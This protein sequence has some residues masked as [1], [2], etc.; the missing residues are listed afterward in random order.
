MLAL[1]EKIDAKEVKKKHF[2]AAMR[3]IGASI[4]EDTIKRYKD[5]ET[6]YLRSAKAALERTPQTYTG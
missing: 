2:D 3:K 1:R 5:I 4:T 6:N